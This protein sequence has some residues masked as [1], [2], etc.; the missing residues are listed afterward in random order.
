M[1]KCV[2][3]AHADMLS[4]RVYVSVWGGLLKVLILLVAPEDPFM[5]GTVRTVITFTFVA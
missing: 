3:V 4:E 5:S 1:L 2:S